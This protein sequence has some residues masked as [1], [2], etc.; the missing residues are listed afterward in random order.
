MKSQK[1]KRLEKAGFKIGT[2]REFLHLSDEESALIELKVRLIEMLRDARKA[3]AMTQ[4]ELAKLLSSSQSRIAKVES[5]PADVSLDLICRALFALGV[6]RQ[7]IG[8]K[9]ASKRAA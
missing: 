1:K 8:K 6:S 7:D 4:E 2:V 9:L 5:R 3:S